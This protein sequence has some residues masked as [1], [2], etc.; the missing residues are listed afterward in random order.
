LAAN[1]FE[2]SGPGAAA[3][4]QPAGAALRRRALLVAAAAAVAAGGCALGRKAILAPPLTLA[5]SDLFTVVPGLQ[6]AFAQAHRGIRF[7][8]VPATIQT[9]IHGP[10][11]PAG[12]ACWIENVGVD[13][14]VSTQDLAPLDALLRQRNFQASTLLPGT[15]AAFALG[16]RQY[17]L[18]V[19]QY[20]L[21]VRWRPDVFAAAGL[22]PP[23]A[24]WDLDGFEAAA[25]SLS[26]AIAAG[27][28]A[29]VASV[30]PPP[31]DMTLL[32]DPALWVAFA[33]GFGG[34]VLAGGRFAFDAAAVTG[35]EHLVSLLQRFSAVQAP[36][37]APPAP[38]ALTFDAWHAAARGGAG[39]GWAYARL[40]RLPARPVITTRP[41]GEGIYQAPHLPA[42]PQQLAAAVTAL[43]WLYGEAPQA[44]LRAAG[45]VPVLA[46][47]AA[48]Q[49][50]WQGQSPADRAVGDWQNFLPFS[51][52]WPA[53]PQPAYLLSALAAAIAGQGDIRDLAAQAAQQMNAEL[54]SPAASVPG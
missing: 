7:V 18:P 21:A 39:S 45:F 19:E 37:G 36:G 32:Q 25:T 14:V 16:G 3:A 30:L 54:P 12:V 49:A 13:A 17:G 20:P 31:G 46:D 26:A 2:L 52:G 1:V 50:F 48:Q 6:Q 9:L 41:V 24:T 15:Y 51:A 35:L 29:Q 27:R 22:T 42:A 34:T 43:T 8:S 11:L 33:L 38:Y 44:L 4:G 53:I 10:T 40:P 28:V 5:D 47:P 23:A